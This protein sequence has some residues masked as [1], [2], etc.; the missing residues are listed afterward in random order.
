MLKCGLHKCPS[1]CHQVSDHSAI[2]CKVP[3]TQK[4]SKGHNKQ[5]KCHQN[6]PKACQK[7]ES[8][9]KDAEK[10]AQK[11]LQEK[12]KRDDKIQRHLKE[13]AKLDEEME[14]IIRSMEDA[15]LDSEQKAILAQKR[16]DLAAAKERAESSQKPQHIDPPS[17]HNEKQTNT[18]NVTPQKSSPVPSRPVTTS[19]P[20]QRSKLRDHLLAAVKHNLS[21]S[22]KEW[23]RQKDQ[24]NAHNPAIDE[25]MDMIGLEE[26]KAQV[27]K[28]KAKVDTSVRQGINLK[29]ER[30]GL[31]LLG[32][33][34]TGIILLNPIL[35]SSF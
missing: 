11:D 16:I 22:K 6:A 13:V 1:S 4:C 12:L 34:G 28:I 29:K 10:R 2:L 30:L 20:S 32:N 31:V 3:L 18:T 25:I 5:W 14:Q 23:Q 35:Q 21:P 8:E 19:T 24:E 15:R 33:P 7:C 26:V 9:R 27:L 17:T